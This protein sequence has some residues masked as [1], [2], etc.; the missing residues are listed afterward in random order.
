MAV[1]KTRE[2]EEVTSPLKEKPR[3]VQAGVGSGGVKKTLFTKEKGEQ[4][5]HGTEEV[6]NLAEGQKLQR[7]VPHSNSTMQVSTCNAL[8]PHEERMEQDKVVSGKGEGEKQGSRR[9]KRLPRKEGGEKGFD[10]AVQIGGKK[11]EL[12]V[13]DLM[14]I[15]DGKRMRVDEQEGLGN[16]KVKAGLADQP[17]RAQ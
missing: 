3:E 5:M 8:K 16:R 15:E 2:E 17:R 7:L 12:D 14:E 4:I 1:E 13:E 11:R 10:S 6:T 9:F